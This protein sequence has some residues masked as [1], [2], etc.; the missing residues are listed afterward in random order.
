MFRTIDFTEKV[1]PYL[2]NDGKIIVI[3][4]GA[5][6]LFLQSEKAREVLNDPS[7]TRE[8]IIEIAKNFYQGVKEGKNDLLLN[9]AM[10]CYVSSKALINAYVRWFLARSVK[11]GQQVYV[12]C[13]GHCKTNL[14]GENAPRTAEKGAETPIYL[15]NLPFVV[16]DEIQGKFLRDKKV[17]N[18]VDEISTH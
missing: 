7:L 11:Q 13:P 15:V 6:L 9:P 8:K 4:S 3:S 2:A 16:N 12:V 18:W 17:I 10:G 5:G 1:Q 14:G